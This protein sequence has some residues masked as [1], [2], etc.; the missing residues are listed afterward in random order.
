MGMYTEIFVN[1]NLKKET[2][3]EVL[4]VLRA[5]CFEGDEEHLK[6]FPIRWDRLFS[7]G[8]YYTPRTSC[9]SLKWDRISE[10]WSLLGKGDIKNYE[11]E[12]E[13][14]FD[15]IMPWVD[16]SPGEFIGYKRYEDSDLPTLVVKKADGPLTK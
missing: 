3:D 10:A 13:Q 9:A 15:W 16:A 2:P 14:F 5:M 8:S 12:I 4:N 6:G 1:V 11:R 7:D